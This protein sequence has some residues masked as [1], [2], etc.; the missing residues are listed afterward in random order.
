VNF[1]SAAGIVLAN[2]PVNQM[3]TSATRTWN[4]LNGDYVPQDSELGQLSNVNFGKVVANTTYADD[5]IHGW[6][7]AG[8]TGRDSSRC[9]TRSR[10][11]SP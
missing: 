8:T 2:N 3:V 5:V 11:G 6:G 1:E 4:D 7:R 9:S 10:P